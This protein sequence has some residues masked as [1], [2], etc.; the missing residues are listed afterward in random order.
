MKNIGAR[1]VIVFLVIGSVSAAWSCPKTDEPK[2]TR[3]EDQEARELALQFT[4]RLSETKDL[5]SITNDLYFSDFIERY[6]NFKANDAGAKPVDLYF[7]PGLDYNSQLLTDADSKDW[8]RF[9]VVV[10][11]F[12]FFGFVR[13]L[14]NFPDEITDLKDT[15]MYPSGVI[16]LL[17]SNPI[18]ANMMVRKEGMKA[19]G[20]V[21]DMRAVTAIL[22]QAVTMMREQQKG[23]PPV[24]KHKEELVR[25]AKKDA[26]FKPR[27][28]VTDEEFFGFPKGTRILFIKTALGFELMLARDHDRIRVFWSEI[29]HD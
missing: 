6:R 13:V 4:L 12:L 21:E 3:V 19:V 7:A 25:L 1:I 15:G 14:K 17:N 8:T 22:E 24:I 10:N 18:L 5:S 28:E 11:E 20:T 23:E 16:K 2:V 27:L 9:Y 29:I 26:F